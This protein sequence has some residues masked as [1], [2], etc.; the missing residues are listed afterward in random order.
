MDR[1]VRRV[2]GSRGFVQGQP[3]HHVIVFVHISGHK[4]LSGPICAIFHII[5]VNDQPLLYLR[6]IL[7]AENRSAVAES[8]SEEPIVGC[9]REQR[10]DVGEFIF[11]RPLQNLQQLGAGISEILVSAMIQG[12]LSLVSAAPIRFLGFSGDDRFENAYGKIVIIAVEHVIRAVI[13]ILIGSGRIAE[14]T[15]LLIIGGISHPG[16]WQL[17]T[18]ENT[19]GEGTDLVAIPFVLAAHPYARM[20]GT[21]GEGQRSGGCEFCRLGGERLDAR[22]CHHQNRESQPPLHDRR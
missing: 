20:V 12:P 7:I 4:R 17:L 14:F 2:P 18:V 9:G 19:P 10:H 1:L 8:L 6:F 11:R 16:P 21:H 5:G 13:R 3:H 15:F 22:H